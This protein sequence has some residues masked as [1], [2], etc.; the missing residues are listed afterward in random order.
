MVD[1]STSPSELSRLLG[2]TLNKLNY[3]VYVLG[4][5]SFY[6]TFEI[7][8]KN[9]GVRVIR[10]PDNQ[11]KH[12]QRRLK[13]ILEELYVPH[14][15]ASAFIKG[16]GIVDNAGRHIKR[17]FV[18]NAD[19]SGFYDQINFGRVRGLLMARPYELQAKTATLIANLCCVD[20]VL[21]QGAPTSPIISNMIC[22]KMDREL[23]FLAKEISARYSRYAD[24]MTISWNSFDANFSIEDGEFFGLG[25]EFEAVVVRNGFEVNRSKT[26]LQTFSERQVVTGLKV[27]RKVNVD[28][29]YI[30]VTKAMIHS[31]SIDYDAAVEKFKSIMGDG[32]SPI[33]SVVHG[34]INFIGMVKGVE[35]TVYQ[36][37]AE[38]F[39]DLNLDLKARTAPLVRNSG[40]EEMLH[41]RAHR[42]RSRLEQCVWVV[43]FDGVEGIGVDAQLVQGT[44]F[45]LSGKRI[46][47]ANHLFDKAG[48]AKEC[49]LYRIKNPGQKFLARL[50]SGCKYSDVA[51]LDFVDATPNIPHLE[52]ASSPIGGGYKVSVV[53]FPQ[54]QLGHDSVSILTCEVVNSF[55]RS[56]FRFGEVGVSIVSGNSGGPVVNGYM[57]VV[58]MALTGT[59]VAFDGNRHILE[60]NN[61]FIMAE[62]FGS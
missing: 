58:G 40:L 23:S 28:R 16:R 21:P 42:N 6:S 33:D 3:V 62:H 27:N 13:T 53:G 41:F 57:Q 47:T 2:T 11:L 22:R 26:R 55:T 34:R 37:L 59:D 50:I 15:A 38:K 61:A 12:L 54:L 5:S 24:D 19:I 36:S 29:R 43:S 44:A 39:N 9:G 20:G 48:K 35:S 30:R 18:F 4:V 56:K 45:A 32:A 14:P 17:K 52:K 46:F 51:E 31:I 7:H 60:G 10:S 1:S 8:K 25:G 49:Y